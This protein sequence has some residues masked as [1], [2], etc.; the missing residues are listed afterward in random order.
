MD[1]Y[2]NKVPPKKSYSVTSDEARRRFI[3]VW[4]SGTKTIKE[5]S[6]RVYFFGP[7]SNPS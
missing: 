6:I 2:T 5:V 3:A 1:K 4:N 7:Y